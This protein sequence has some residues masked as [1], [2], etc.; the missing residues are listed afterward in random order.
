MIHCDSTDPKWFNPVVFMCADTNLFATI[1]FM[2]GLGAHS[3]W[4]GI[5]RLTSTANKQE[6]ESVFTVLEANMHIKAPGRSTLV[7]CTKYFA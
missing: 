5:Q 2:V 4:I 7:S 1:K 6:L 3:C